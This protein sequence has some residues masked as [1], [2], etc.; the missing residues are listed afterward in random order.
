M[1]ALQGCH[2]QFFGPVD[3][4]LLAIAVVT[5]S[6]YSS[7]LPM[8]LASLRTQCERTLSVRLPQELKVFAHVATATFLFILRQNTQNNSDGS[9]ISQRGA[10]LLFAIIFAKKLHENEKKWT[11]S[12]APSRSVSGMSLRPISLRHCNVRPVYPLTLVWCQ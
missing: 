8:F 5:K 11:E 9:R 3:T 10:N 4:D 7:N 1:N 2:S 6:G 12:F